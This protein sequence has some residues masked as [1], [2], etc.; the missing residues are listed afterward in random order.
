MTPLSHNQELQLDYR[1]YR[2]RFRKPLVTA[3]GEWVEREGVVI[4]LQTSDGRVGYGEVAPI[5]WF[6]PNGKGLLEGSTLVEQLGLNEF[7][8]TIQP[9]CLRQIKLPTLH[10]G[11]ECAITQLVDPTLPGVR[12]PVAGLLPAGED[13]L[14]TLSQQLA[15]GRRAYKWKIGVLPCKQEIELANQLVPKL[16]K[17]VRL[18]LDANGSLTDDD[19][20]AWLSWCMAHREV[21]DYLEQPLAVGREQEMM[22]RADGM[23]VPIALD[24][25]VVGVE[26]LIEVARH[27]PD[28]VLIVKPSLLGSRAQYLRWRTGH[29]RQRVVYSTSF[30]TVI[31][32]KAVWELAALDWPPL[33][34]AGLDASSAL[35]DDGLC[36]MRIGWELSN[37]DWP[38]GLEH[39]VWEHL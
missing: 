3:Y 26:S 6:D 24:E 23:D 30:E 1:L 11:M 13:A 25:S 22:D 17:G 5:P 8:S 35:E 18:R 16:P 29:P 20:K 7:G 21:V 14:E 12:V 32:L 39:E 31:G 37:A 27:C 38:N 36:P 10:W 15:L 9:T 19:Y 28:A 4:R 2:R 34:P 33:A